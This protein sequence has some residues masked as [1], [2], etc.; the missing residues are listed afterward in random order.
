MGMETSLTKASTKGNSLRT[1][2][3]RS[4]V[5][6]FELKEGDNL[7]WTLKVKSGKLVIEVEPKKSK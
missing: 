6:Q 4:I 1:T 5:S 3:P 7:D 2:V